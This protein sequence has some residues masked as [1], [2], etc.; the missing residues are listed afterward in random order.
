MDKKKLAISIVT[1]NSE[2]IFKVLENIKQE[3]GDNDS[4][5]FLIFD[6]NSEEEYRNRL[7]EYQDFADI[8]FNKEN[9][10]F[11]FGHNFNLLSA[12]EDYFLVFNPDIILTRKNLE[13]MINIMDHDETIALLVP[14]VLNAD[15]TTQHLIRDRV[16]VFDYFLRFVPFKF[17]KRIFNKRLETYECRRIENSR[18]TDIRIGSGCFMLIRGND[19]KEIN[20]FDDRYFMYFEDYDLCLELKKRG[21]RVVYTPFSSVVHYYERGAHKNWKLFKLFIK[22]MVKYFNKWGW[23]F[24]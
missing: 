19:F 16:S 22:S 14:K 4:F 12:K 20:G 15:G 21:K 7:R 6:N 23:R 3:F 17:V 10:G 5:R 11:G 9:N 8:T 18:M 13:E 2:H 24:F 1:Y